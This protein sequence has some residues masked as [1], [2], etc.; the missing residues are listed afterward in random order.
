[1]KMYSLICKDM[2]MEKCDYVAMAENKED[3]IEI[4]EEHMKKFH[5]NEEPMQPMEKYVREEETD[6]DM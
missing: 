6:E 2:G 1:M 3:A 5:P 4:M